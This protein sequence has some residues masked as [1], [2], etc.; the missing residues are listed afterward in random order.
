[1]ITP[2]D[3]REIKAERWYDVLGWLGLALIVLGTTAQII[4]IWA[5]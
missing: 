1:V 5:F 2:P 4:A 3:P